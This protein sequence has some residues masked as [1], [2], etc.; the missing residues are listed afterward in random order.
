[1]QF[2]PSQAPEMLGPLLT[3]QA[4]SDFSIFGSDRADVADTIEAALKS[5]IQGSDLVDHAGQSATSLPESFYQAT[6]IAAKLRVLRAF[7][8][9]EQ[10]TIATDGT[11]SSI[12]GI[13]P[14]EKQT[15]DMSLAS[16]GLGSCRD[17]HESLLTSLV[18]AS[19]LPQ[20]AQCIVDHAMLFRA[21]EQYLFDAVTNRDVVSDDPWTRFLWDWV[22]DAEQA[23]DDGAM[24]LSSVDLAY[25]GVYSVWKNDLGKPVTSSCLQSD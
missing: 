23:A 8:Q 12:S 4:L 6:T 25:L 22:A 24:V 3:E 15:S 16:N 5:N 7:I 2:E 13:T 18:T 9:E 21:R 20:E 14:S 1:M 10:K 17:I 11:R 19:D